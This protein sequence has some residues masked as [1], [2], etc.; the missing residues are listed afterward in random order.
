MCHIPPR[1]NAWNLL[2]FVAVAA[3]GA[4]LA[5]SGQ[6]ADPV[7]SSRERT[8]AAAQLESL[9]LYD[10]QTQV[11]ETALREAAGPAKPAIAGQ[12]ALAISRGMD[13]AA[14]NVS[15]D[16]A[17][18][19]KEAKQ[20]R[21]SQLL[22]EYPQA[23][24]STLQL[25]LLEQDYQ[26]AERF[27]S[28]WLEDPA[29]N[30]GRRDA[31]EQIAP[32]LPRFT[33]LRDQINR[34]L[35][36]LNTQLDEKKSARGTETLETQVTNQEILLTKLN[37]LH[38]WA[39][40]Y[41]GLTQ[42]DEGE[43]EKAWSLARQTLQDLLGVVEGTSYEKVES[44][45]LGLETPWRARAVIALGLTESGLGNQ[46]A[47]DQVFQWLGDP[48]VKAELFDQVRYWRLQGLL[49]SQRWKPALQFVEAQPEYLT[50]T[51]TPG[52]A[53]F[54]IALIRGG[55]RAA[56]LGDSASGSKL[57][58]LGIA[59][60]VRLK[61]TNTLQD[62]NVKLKLSQ[63]AAG[64]GLWLLGLEGMSLFQAAEKSHEAKDYQLAEKK[65][66]AAL[67]TPDAKAEPI[68][69]AELR[70]QLAWSQYRQEQWESASTQFKQVV[71]PLRRAKPEIA[72]QAGWMVFASLQQ[73]ADKDPKFV[74][75]AVRALDAFAQ[76]FPKSS[77]GAK[78]GLYRAKLTR[79]DKMAADSAE[80]LA[81]MPAS[82]PNYRDAQA[83]L[84]LIYKQQLDTAINDKKTKEQAAL[85]EKLLA[86]VDRY[87]EL[88]KPSVATGDQS[89]ALTLV[90]LGLLREPTA[91][92]QA[93]FAAYVN[94]AKPLALALSIED[95]LRH[96]WLYRAF[97][98]SL[99][100][101]DSA[102][103]GQ[104]AEQLVA[105]NPDSPFAAPAL[106][107]QVKKLD[108]ALAGSLAAAERQATL[109]K[110]ASIYRKLRKTIRDEPTA[111]REN[112]NGSAIVSRLGQYEQELGNLDQAAV[113]LEALHA[114]FPTDKR[115][116]LRLMTLQQLRGKA[117]ATLELSRQLLTALTVGSDDWLS[118]KYHQ[119]WA[120][121]KTDP[122]K[123]R[124]VFRQLKV[125]LPPEKWNNWRERLQQL[126]QQ[127][128]V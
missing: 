87:L 58:Q 52:K 28:R 89:L 80:K 3:I 19:S 95:S 63:T 70:Y 6:S 55:S 66:A 20:A 1:R 81:R 54:A 18:K 100:E 50:G 16:D 122:E 99:F 83:E 85:R 21:L 76:D 75:S 4:T 25:S 11:L 5:A 10:L 96:E 43:R 102:I 47:A 57:I 15:L 71:G 108:E 59:G 30:T 72:Q 90:G 68:F 92:N 115:T 118:A 12:L 29:A 17:A 74:P 84:A 113:Q 33:V 107:A 120:L 36:G 109:E 7:W 105:A 98:W 79:N 101:G 22:T 51:P 125:L 103:A 56:S 126:E 123:A 67:A 111:L 82:D 65:L 77:L 86:T 26:A 61:Q 2:A 93:K 128:A 44:N 48:A 91:D 88:P 117:P 8:T 94:K 27:I 35:E 41:S 45:S 110:A 127:L 62:L 73:L 112:K 40:Y 23:A 53:S 34:E 39:N 24:T 119:L 78:A 60:L 46:T 38:G 13:T 114:A 37:Y 116:L 9:R 124:Q 42:S 64:Q 49:Y 32:L 69:A 14:T 121:A 104:Y 31:N 106:V 97:Q